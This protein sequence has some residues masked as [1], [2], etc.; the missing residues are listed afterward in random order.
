MP[1]ESLDVVFRRPRNLC[2]GS[3]LMKDVQGENVMLLW[4]SSPAVSQL[5]STTLR[6][7]IQD[8]I[9]L[10]HKEEYNE[11]VLFQNLRDTSAD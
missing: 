5:R 2:N 9:A 1:L 8:Q 7:N 4:S 3:F 11:D 10:T 6:P